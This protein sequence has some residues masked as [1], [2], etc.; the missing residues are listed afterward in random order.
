[1][2]EQT[3]ERQLAASTQQMIE[4]YKK[5]LLAER[6]ARRAAL[7][8]LSFTI[9]DEDVAEFVRITDELTHQYEEEDK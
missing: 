6:R 4:A 3:K 5:M 8:V 1:M 9:P 7:E 2:P